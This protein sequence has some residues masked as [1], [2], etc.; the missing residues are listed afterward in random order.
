[1]KPINNNQTSKSIISPLGFGWS[2]GF[3]KSRKK[4]RVPIKETEF[5]NQLT[6]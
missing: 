5:N 6:N 1:M 2:T 4:V 3:A